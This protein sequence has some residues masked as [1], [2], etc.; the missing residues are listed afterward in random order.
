M[1]THNHV[2]SQEIKN[3]LRELLVG[4]VFPP[5]PEDLSGSQHPCQ[6]TRNT[7]YPLR[8]GV[9]TLLPYQRSTNQV[10]EQPKLHSETLS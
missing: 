1:K 2:F 4:G 8:Q 3:T 7:L 5:L 10:S 9:D 6:V